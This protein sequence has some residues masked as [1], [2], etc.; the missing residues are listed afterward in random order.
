MLCSQH[1]LG[2]NKA[3]LSIV[4]NLTKPNDKVLKPGE[5]QWPKCSFF[6]VYDGHGGKK[7]AGEFLKIAFIYY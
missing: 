7:C 2:I 3:S 6:A 1:S 4:L 5:L